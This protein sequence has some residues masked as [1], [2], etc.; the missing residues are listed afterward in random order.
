MHTTWQLAGAGC[1][2]SLLGGAAAIVGLLSGGVS[3]VTMGVTSGVVTA[4][5]GIPC[6]RTLAA[7]TGMCIY[8]APDIYL[9]QKVHQQ[10]AL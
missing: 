3:A 5:L 1:V 9:R 8:N 7:L 2:T 10:M 4:G 6:L